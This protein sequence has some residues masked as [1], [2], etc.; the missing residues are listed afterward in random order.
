MTCTSRLGSTVPA[1]AAMIRPAL[2]C[3]LLLGS[4]CAINPWPEQ[5][6]ATGNIILSY[7][8]V[9]EPFRAYVDMTNGKSR[10]DYYG[11]KC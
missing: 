1:A 9:V 3:V 6:T 4:S 7:A 10:I 8:N 5:Y 2:L 11:G